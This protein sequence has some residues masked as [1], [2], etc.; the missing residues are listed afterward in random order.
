MKTLYDVVTEAIDP[1]MKK[2]K[3][4]LYRKIRNAKLRGKDTTDIEKEYNDFLAQY[5]NHKLN[6]GTPS[7]Q[8]QNFDG[9]K[10]IQDL[11]K[12]LITCSDESLHRNY[13]SYYTKPKNPKRFYDSGFKDFMQMCKDN[14][15]PAR[16]NDD[17]CMLSVKYSYTTKTID[18]MFL[19]PAVGDTLSIPLDG[20]WGMYGPANS[21]ITAGF[22]TGKIF[23]EIRRGGWETG[24]NADWVESYVISKDTLR[25]I[26]NYISTKFKR[27]DI[28][29]S[30]SDDVARKWIKLDAPC[31]HR[32]GV[33]NPGSPISK[34]QAQKLLDSHEYSWGMDWHFIRWE[35]GDNGYSLAFIDSVNSDMY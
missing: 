8:S 35:R 33:W 27:P 25:D 11:F 18:I 2:R 22:Y 30:N 9:K 4:Y 24:P 6:G 14:L 12:N 5:K 15:P 31:T 1:E 20:N 28:N 23:S 3:D 19:D 32:R 26:Q 21:K 13:I 29:L 16:E 34:L 7:A 17:L 10:L